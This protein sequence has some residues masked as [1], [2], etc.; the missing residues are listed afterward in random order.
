MQI[1]LVFS[2][3]GF[4]LYAE[5]IIIVFLLYISQRKDRYLGLGLDAESTQ[6]NPFDT[7]GYPCSDGSSIGSLQGNGE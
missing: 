5:R 4:P 6:E 1:E 3:P 2:F 7:R